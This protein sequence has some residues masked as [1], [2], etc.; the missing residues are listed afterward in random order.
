[1]GLIRF[2]VFFPVISFPHSTYRIYC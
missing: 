2:A 1:M